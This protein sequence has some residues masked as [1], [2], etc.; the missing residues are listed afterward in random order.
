MGGVL[1]LPDEGAWSAGLAR[2]GPGMDIATFQAARN[3]PVPYARWCEYS[4]GRIGGTEYWSSVLRELAIPPTPEAVGMASRAYAVGEWGRLEESILTLMDGLRHPRRPDHLRLGILSNSAPEHDGVV[5][6][7]RPRFHAVRFSH[8]TGLR[9]PDPEAYQDAAAGLQL[10]PGAIVFIDDK[11][12]N[13][14]AASRLGFHAVTFSAAEPGAAARLSTE[15][16]KL[17]IALGA[18]EEPGRPS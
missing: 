6:I 5:S 3:A 12:R 14:D 10:P 8:L 1:T 13:T 18:G 7:L 15:L 9:K 17:G 16:R 2:L 4:V 11:P